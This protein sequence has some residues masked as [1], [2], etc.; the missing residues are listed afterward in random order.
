M[1][2]IRPLGEFFGIQCRMLVNGLA[3]CVR[4]FGQVASPLSHFLV[5]A[6]GQDT[7]QL[8]RCSHES[9][10]VNRWL[11][12]GHRTEGLSGGFVS[13]RRLSTSAAHP[14]PS[15]EPVLARSCHISLCLLPARLHQR[16]PG[17]AGWP[18]AKT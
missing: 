1:V 11:L 7:A 8:S 3:A 16:H 10:H 13:V 5:E 12:L 4:R 17:E 14:R 2:R 6:V 9:T 15:S 18:S